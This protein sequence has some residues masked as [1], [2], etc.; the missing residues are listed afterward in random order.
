MHLF[1][2][3]SSEHIM[4]WFAVNMPMD[5]DT[6]GSFTS[7]IDIIARLRGIPGHPV[8]AG[9]FY[10]TW[11]VKV[12]LLYKNGATKS[13]KVGIG[14]IRKVVNQLKAYRDFGSPEVSLLD[15]YLCEAGGSMNYLY[16]IKDSLSTKFSELKYH[17]FGYHVLPFGYGKREDHDFGLHFLPAPPR[18]SLH[19]NP[20][21]AFPVAAFL[22]APVTPIRP[23][24]SNLAE[25]I[26]NFV[27]EQKDKGAYKGVFQ[28]TVMFCRECRQLQL[29]RIKEEYTCPNCGDDLIAQT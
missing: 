16:N 20:F 24:F 26:D 9:H 22:R 2:P 7:D 18:F 19:P 15:I 23:P 10:R 1:V 11:E 17:S 29:I 25:R 12:S 5:L 4:N 14:K 8:A 28:H 21:M 3:L 13:L 27:K 6:G